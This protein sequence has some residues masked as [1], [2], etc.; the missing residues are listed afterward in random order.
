MTKAL[1]RSVAV[2]LVAVACGNSRKGDVQ[3]SVVIDSPGNGD[4]VRGSA[5]HIELAANG[6]EL[7]PAADERAGTAHHHLFLDVDPGPLDQKIPSGV[8]GIIHLGRAQ[9]EFHWDSVAPG[10]HRIIAIL[11]DWQHVPLPGAAAD[12]VRFVVQP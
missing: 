3:P 4:T 10:P 1:V 6:V 11:A 12:T 7:A 8:S 2:A 9:T 5:V